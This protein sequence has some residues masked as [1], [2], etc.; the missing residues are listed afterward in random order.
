MSLMS[1]QVLEQVEFS[2]SQLDRAVAA[3]HA[4]GDEVHFQVG[5]LQS[6]DL[7]RPTATEQG[8]DAREQLRQGK[9]LDQ[10]VIRPKIQPE[11]TIVDTVAR[12]QNQH[13]RVD[14]TLP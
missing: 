12:R 9:R 14:V 13:R 3:H 10:V 1:E 2:T 7:R 4:A 11:D 8:A 5:G 6:K